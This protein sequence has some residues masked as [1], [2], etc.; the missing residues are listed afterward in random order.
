MTKFDSRLP[1][2]LTLVALFSCPIAAR[3]QEN[4]ASVPVTMT[5]TVNVASDSRPPELKR[6]DLIVK[7]NKKRVPVTEWLPAQG[8]RAGLDLFILID[9]AS[10]TS[11]GSQLNDLRT[12]VSGQP[13]TTAVGI[14]YM[15]NATVQIAQNFTTDH[16]QAAKAIRLPTGYVGAFGSPYLS[17]IDLMKR[18]PEHPNRRR[19]VVMVSDGIDRARRERNALVNPD[20]D[21]AN[22]AAQRTGTIVHTIYFP[23]TGHWHR[24][25]FDANNGAMALGKVSDVTGGE[26]FFIGLPAPVSFQ[27]YLETLQRIFNNQYLLSFGANPGKRAG[28]QNVSIDTEVKGVDFSYANA[29]WV[30]AA[31]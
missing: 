15:R 24:N 28:L 16:E 4:T 8:D 18:W 23:G 22:D 12:F 5:V 9:D 6:E 27:P 25:F 19:E 7:V 2:F 1:L 21:R 14:G 17:L 3:G 13:Q 20:V 26:S 30:P 31:K 10:D 29:V 11:L